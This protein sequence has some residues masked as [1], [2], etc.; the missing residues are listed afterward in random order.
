MG[1]SDKQRRKERNEEGSLCA[2]GKR[3]VLSSL[4]GGREQNQRWREKIVEWCA[5]FDQ[6]HLPP[7]L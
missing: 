1:R 2:R 4:L 3:T 6:S 7:R 5:V